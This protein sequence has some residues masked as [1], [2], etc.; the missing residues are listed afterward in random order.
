MRQIEAALEKCDLF[1]A[2]GTSGTVYPAAGFVEIAK[3]YGAQTIRFDITLPPDG[4]QFDQYF[5]VEA[6]K[7]IPKWAGDL[8]GETSPHQ[9]S[10]LLI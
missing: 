10:L 2:I 4:H 6:S 5:H 3:S 8:I 1:I 7:M 9:H